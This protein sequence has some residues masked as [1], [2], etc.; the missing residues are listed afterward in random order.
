MTRGSAIGYWLAAWAI[1]I[2]IL[3]GMSRT[4]S[5]RV[6]IYYGAW[7]SVVFL[8]VTHSDTLSTIFQQGNISAGEI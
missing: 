1:I 6:V 4:R 3:I 8:L 5:G 7:G 2:V